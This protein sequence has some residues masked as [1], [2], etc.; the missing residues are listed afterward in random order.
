MKKIIQLTLNARHPANIW[1]TQQQVAA[2]QYEGSTQ[3]PCG[4]I[5]AM[6]L[7]QPFRI[8]KALGYVSFSV[9]LT[10]QSLISP[11]ESAKTTLLLLCLR[12]SHLTN[13]SILTS[14]LFSMLSEDLIIWAP[15]CILYQ[16]HI[17]LYVFLVLEH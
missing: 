17:Q 16:V 7:S 4:V 8:F 12:T 5:A 11:S 14:T 3:D 1:L 13:N 6:Y 15:P 10:R 9:C 2:A